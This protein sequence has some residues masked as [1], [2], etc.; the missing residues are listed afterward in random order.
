VLR[1]IAARMVRVRGRSLT[2]LGRTQPRQH[3]GMSAVPGLYFLGLHWMHTFKSVVS[4]SGNGQSK[5]F[6]KDVSS[7]AGTRASR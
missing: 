6:T 3:R 2:P 5:V 1:V 7:A 4:I